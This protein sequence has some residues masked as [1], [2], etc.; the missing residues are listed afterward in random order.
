MLTLEKGSHFNW[1]HFEVPEK[2]SQ[3]TVLLSGW[4]NSQSTP[5]GQALARTHMLWRGQ[6]SKLHWLQYKAMAYIWHPT[7]LNVKTKVRLFDLILRDPFPKLTRLPNFL[8]HSDNNKQ[9]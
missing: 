7:S 8:A 4:A 6:N 1:Y 9:V 2:I 3:L 5:G